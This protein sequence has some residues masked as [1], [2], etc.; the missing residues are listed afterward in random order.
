MTCYFH[1]GWRMLGFVLNMFVPVNPVCSQL[2]LAYLHFQ[3]VIQPW[4]LLCLLKIVLSHSLPDLKGIH[5][6]PVLPLPTHSFWADNLK[7]IREVP[8]FACACDVIELRHV[9]AA[10]FCPVDPAPATT[11][12]GT[13]PLRSFVWLTYIQY[14]QT[15][16]L[17]LFNRSLQK[18]FLNLLFRFVALFL[19]TEAVK[20]RLI[21]SC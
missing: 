18:Y 14:D 5:R 11:C 17:A 16:N 20:I 10:C 15:M 4:D 19:G 3:L 8:G 7:V 6:S 9:A 21:F 13:P 12:P 1:I 2:D